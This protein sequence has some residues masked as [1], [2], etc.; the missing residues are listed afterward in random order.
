MLVEG[1][2]EIINLVGK[3]KALSMDQ[4]IKLTG[5]SKDAIYRRLRKELR[6]N[7]LSKP[8]KYSGYDNEHFNS[9][10]PVYRLLKE[11]EMIYREYSNKKYYKPTWSE[12]SIPHLL[13][14]NDT[15]I[16]IKDL[17]TDFRLEYRPSSTGAK[18]QLDALIDFGDCKGALEV[19]LGSESKSDIQ[20]QY[21]TYQSEME[22][23]KL[24]LL[25]IFSTKRPLKIKEWLL[26]VDRGLGITPVFVG[27]NRL[28][29][30]SNTLKE[31]IR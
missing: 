25:Y 22:L 3:H 21:K 30:L 19:D 31:M 4:I 27:F 15:L 1:D 28:H 10:I 13:K 24:P 2:I 12:K 23:F 16:A 6:G 26:E 11:G 14:V 8:H 5:R 29:N 7:Y 18:T 17:Y 20:S 9:Y